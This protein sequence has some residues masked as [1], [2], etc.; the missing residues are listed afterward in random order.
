ML[1]IVPYAIFWSSSCF[2]IFSCWSS[3]LTFWF[4]FWFFTVIYLVDIFILLLFT[5]GNLSW[6]FWL[7]ALYNLGIL[8]RNRDTF[9]FH[10]SIARRRAPSISRPL[11]IWYCHKR[12]YTCFTS[13]QTYPIFRVLNKA[14]R[15]SLVNPPSLAL[16]GCKLTMRYV[17]KTGRVW[18]SRCK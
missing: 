1:A 18:V 4:S 7:P 8:H 16:M 12:S 13:S 11:E 5:P 9:I 2:F 6:C 14:V 15:K 17:L 10:S 3:W